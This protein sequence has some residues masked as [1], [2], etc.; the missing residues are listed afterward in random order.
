[1]TEPFDPQALILKSRKG[2]LSVG[3][4]HSLSVHVAGLERALRNHTQGTISASRGESVSV[5]LNEDC[6]GLLVVYPGQREHAVSLPLA[7]P[8]LAM[9][10]LV[11]SLRE[12]RGQP[13]NLIASP[14]A[15]TQADL[16]ALARASKRQPTKAVTSMTLDDLE[17]SLEDLT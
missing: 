11:K 12:R 7:R 2:Q 17:L 14:G 8:D 5:C 1:M 10:F 9:D 15:P 3:E 13:A 6:S 16:V 4:A